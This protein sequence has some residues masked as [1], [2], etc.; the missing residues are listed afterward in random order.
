MPL[1]RNEETEEFDVIISESP[2]STNQRE[3]TFEALVQLLPALLQ[4]GIPIPPDVLDYAPLP[5]ELVQK[6][7]EYLQRSQEPS[8]EQQQAQQVAL[9]KEQS[10]SEEN[11]A[12]AALYRVEAQIK[13]FEAQIKQFEAVTDR[14]E[15]INSLDKGGSD[16]KP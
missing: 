3:E 16:G 5:T 7:R 13:Q 8:E 15:A 6:W 4:A 10:E 14:L 2:R 9:A 1:V 12:Q 11:Q